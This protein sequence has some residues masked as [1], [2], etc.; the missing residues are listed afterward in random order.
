M[1]IPGEK[2]GRRV[3]MF[4]RAS[5]NYLSLKNAGI[6]KR[7][8]NDKDA[9]LKFT[10]CKKIV[11]QMAFQVNLDFLNQSYKALNTFGA[12]P[13][14]EQ[15][16]PAR[17]RA[18][19]LPHALLW[20][21]WW[22]FFFTDLFDCVDDGIPIKELPWN[23]VNDTILRCFE[24]DCTPIHL[25]VILKYCVVNDWFFIQSARNMLIVKLACRRI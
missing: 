22:L 24:S 23:Q 4:S 2:N 19:F 18:C 10:E 25:L 21:L 16:C 3:F 1:S 17:A 9:K 20:F 13:Q 11:Q 15:R 8:P 7:K 6:Y 5:Q 12:Y 14:V